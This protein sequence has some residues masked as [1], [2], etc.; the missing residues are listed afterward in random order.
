[1]R[2]EHNF[3]GSL[4][5]WEDQVF[6]AATLFTTYR[7]AGKGHG[8]RRPFKTFPEAIVDAQTDPRALLYAVTDSGRSFC[9]ERGKWRH[10]LGLWD[11]SHRTKFAE[12]Y[13]EAPNINLSPRERKGRKK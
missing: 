3:T 1:M 13:V 11:T 8:D 7:R 10:Y 4:E 6:L 5:E 12:A 2:A 9:I